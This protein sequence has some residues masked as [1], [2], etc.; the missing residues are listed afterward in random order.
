MLTG[1]IM[2]NSLPD[3]GFAMRHS[4]KQYSASYGKNSRK[5]IEIAYINSGGINLIVN[6]TKIYAPE[7]SIVV[8]FRHLPISTETVGDGI[9]S[10]DTV[11]AEFSD[12]DFAS[13]ENESSDGYGLE[14]PFVTMP[15]EKTEKIGVE[16]RRIVSDMT[17]DRDGRSIHA[18]ISFV[19]ILKELADIYAK[20]SG[21]FIKEK[22]VAKIKEYINNNIEKNIPITEIASHIER[23]PNYTGQLFKRNVGMTV[24]EYANLQKMKKVASLIKEQGLTFSD[25]CASVSLCDVSYGYRL[26]KKHIGLTPGEFIRANSIGE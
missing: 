6:G 26:F 10:H 7:G 14:I 20:D 13:G 18:S 15:S 1:K 12:L 21:I 25:A 4:R 2:F 3:I 22:N 9:H 23:S 16:L 5:S 17:E 8:L 11:L 19:S 24:A